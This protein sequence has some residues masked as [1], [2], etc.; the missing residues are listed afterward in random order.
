MYNTTNNSAEVKKYKR[1]LKRV[2]VLTD[3]NC[4]TEARI[5]IARYFGFKEEIKKLEAIKVCQNRQNCIYPEQIE[6]RNTITKNMI[7]TIRFKYG[8]EVSKEVHSQL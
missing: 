7:N 5:S 8:E 2:S 6:S 3:C 1:F 4:H